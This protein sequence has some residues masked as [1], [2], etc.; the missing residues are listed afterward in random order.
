MS[1]TYLSE[2]KMWGLNFAPRNWAFC[3]GQL[4]PIVQNTA[5]F[6]LLGTTYGGNGTTTFALPDMRGRVPIHSGSSAGPGLTSYTLG[7]SGGTESVTLTTANL[8]AHT[9]THQQPAVAA[10][11]N[12]AAPGA[13]ARLAATT[14]RGILNYSTAAADTTLASSSTGPTGSSTP[15]PNLQPYLT[16]NF[17]ISLSGIYPSRN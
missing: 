11:G 12:T 16:V 5:L 14:A 9:H 10:V 4:L 17:C 15:V 1:G 6:S 13:T 8:P 7:Q 2:I 3:N